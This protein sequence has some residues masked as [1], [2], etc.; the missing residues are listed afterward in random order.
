[1]PGPDASNIEPFKRLYRIF[2]RPDYPAPDRRF[3]KNPVPAGFGL[4]IRLSTGLFNI[5]FGTVT[6]CR[7]CQNY[8]S[9]YIK[10]NKNLTVIKAEEQRS[11]N[12]TFMSSA[13]REEGW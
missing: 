8:N 1:M 6:V 3:F 5:I 13:K 4:K 10:N 11:R 7:K 9:V 2:G 12:H